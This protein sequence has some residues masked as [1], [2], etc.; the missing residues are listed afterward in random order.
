VPE[1]RVDVQ[2]GE[3]LTESL[4]A[5]KVEG[6]L[7]RERFWRLQQRGV[8]EPRVP[9]LSVLFL[10]LLLSFGVDFSNCRPKK[11]RTRTVEYEKHAWKRFE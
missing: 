8:V 6:N 1:E 10:P 4:R 5:L 2:L 11:R 3:D 7:F 9:V